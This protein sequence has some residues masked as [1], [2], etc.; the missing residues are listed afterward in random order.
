MSIFMLGGLSQTDF[1]ISFKFIK[2]RFIFLPHNYIVSVIMCR[3]FTVTE[4]NNSKLYL[5]LCKMSLIELH[6]LEFNLK[7]NIT[8]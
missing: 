5:S 4:E 3:M 8:S 2:P 6:F 7:M 1:N